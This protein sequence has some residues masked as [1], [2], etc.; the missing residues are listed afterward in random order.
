MTLSHWLWT[1]ALVV[2]VELF[3]FGSPLT[4]VVYVNWRSAQ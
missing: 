4:L 2:A 3:G 1:V